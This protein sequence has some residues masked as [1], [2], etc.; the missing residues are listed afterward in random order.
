MLQQALLALRAA[1]QAD[2]EP[3]GGHS[4]FAEAKRAGEVLLPTTKAVRQAADR[5]ED[6]VADNLWPLPTY[7]EMLFIL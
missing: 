3:Q 1:L 4:T 2:D 5:L 7:Q 6:V